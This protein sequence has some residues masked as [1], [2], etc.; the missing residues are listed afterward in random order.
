M[1]HVSQPF[2]NHNGGGVGFGPDGSSTSRSATAAPKATPKAMG[3]GSTPCWPRSCASTSTAARPP[4]L[5]TRFPPTTRSS[6]TA[7]AQPEIWLSGLRNPW[8]F[9]FDRQT[10]DLWIGDVGQDAWEEIDVAR[11]GVGGL[12]FGWNRIEGFH[13]YDPAQGCDETGLTS[14]VAEYGHDQ[15]CAVIGGVVV[16]H[17]AAAR[18][19]AAT[20]SATTARTTCGSSIPAGD[21]RREP[22]LVTNMG[23]SVSSIGEAAD[24]S[25]YATSL[26]HGELLRI[27]GS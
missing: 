26:G 21:G 1:L 20:C 9:R 11:A 17:P 25:V 13:C 24:G 5:R 22:V 27:A 18:S 7:G 4:G 6:A 23:R 8:R 14:P 3:S 10:G 12:D 15:G 16:R 19:T 2:A